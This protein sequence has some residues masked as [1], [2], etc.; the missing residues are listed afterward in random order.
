MKPIEILPEDIRAAVKELGSFVDCSE[1]DLMR[2]YKLAVK[3]TH[4]RAL[5]SIPVR[6]AMCSEVISTTADTSLAEIEAL[7]TQHHISGIPV[8]DDEGRV[9]GVVSER[10]LLYKLEDP[11]FFS[12]KDR[13]RHLFGD[14][15][16]QRKSRAS[17]LTELMSTPPVTV[18]EE[19]SLGQVATLLLERKINRVPVVD[20]AD[21]LIGIISRADL[22]RVLH[23]KQESN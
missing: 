5:E 1:A 14:D 20:A 18:T 10:D 13:L 16:A 22:V 3:H 2:I 19:T 8:V 11:R 4:R 7:L 15:T 17:N 6:K 12:L 23:Q 21:K 9:I